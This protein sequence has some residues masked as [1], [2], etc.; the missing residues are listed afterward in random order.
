MGQLPLAGRAAGGEE[1]DEDC[2]AA[3]V[4]ERDLLAVRDGDRLEVG[5]GTPFFESAAAPY[6][7]ESQQRG[8]HHGSYQDHIEHTL[9]HR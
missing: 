7:P 9:Q 5:S 4:R 6:H 3:E 1:V 2:F 8:I